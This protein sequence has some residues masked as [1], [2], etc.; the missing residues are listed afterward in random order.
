MIGGANQEIVNNS[1]RFAHPGSPFIKNR[2]DG[3]FCIS[4]PIYDANN[5]RSKAKYVRF[6]LDEA[7]P[8][9]LLTMGKGHPVFTIKLRAR[10]RDGAQ[11]PFSLFR[12]R[13]FEYGQP[14]QQLVDRAVRGL[15][16]P[17]VEGEVLQFQQL[18]QELL[19]ARQEVVDA[20]TKVHHTQHIE[21]L[22]TS[23]LTTARQA[24]DA[25]AERFEQAGAYRTLHPFLFHQSF[26]H[27]GDDKA[28]VDVCDHLHCQL[29]AGGR[30][31]SPDS[32]NAGSLGDIDNILAWFDDVPMRNLHDEPFVQD[33]GDDNRYYE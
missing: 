25:S 4:T 26:R 3:W 21:T 18:T 24:V 1:P 31:L 32:L 16:D 20:H 8:R 29:Q 10:P 19:E 33:G 15:G 6:A 23:A 7:N 14:Y 17:F 12:Q 30:P 28:M 2:S 9:A 11:S 13:I 22:A 27:V 5:N